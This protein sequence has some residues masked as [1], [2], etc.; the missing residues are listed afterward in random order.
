MHYYS[1]WKVSNHTLFNSD[2]SAQI[3][4]NLTGQAW[5][6]G[7]S[8]VLRDITKSIAAVDNPI[9]IASAKFGEYYK[10][11]SC[12]HSILGDYRHR[13]ALEHLEFVP[14]PPLPKRQIE[15]CQDWYRVV[16]TIYARYT[17][18]PLPITSGSLYQRLHGVVD[19]YL[20]WDNT[21]KFTRHVEIHLI[22]FLKDGNMEPEVVGVSK[23]CCQ[24]CDKWI[25]G[26]NQHRNIR[27]SRTS[28]CHRRLYDWSRDTTAHGSALSAELNV[29]DYVYKEIVETIKKYIS[30][31]VESPPQDYGFLDCAHA[32]TTELASSSLTKYC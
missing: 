6:V 13:P 20:S 9:I 5:I 7:R 12:L 2:M 14:V 32:Y 22:K 23:Y 25:E 15:L 31:P 11:T 24:L 21:G 8:A 30:D 27:I 17:G 29:R 4:Q 16:E 28:G 10:G 1:S 26:V 19:E 18:Y 3:Y